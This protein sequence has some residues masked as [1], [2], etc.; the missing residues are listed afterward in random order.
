MYE[1]SDASSLLRARRRL[2]SR[3]SSGPHV[4]RTV[5]L[6]GLTSLFTDVAAEM[7]VTVLPLYLVYVGQFS[8]VA[9]GFVDG[10]QRGA[11]ALVG[12]ASGFVGDRFRRHKEVAATGYGL[13]ALVKLGLATAGTALSAISALVLIDRIG[14]GI[15]TAP[16]DAMISLATPRHELGAAFGVHRALDTTGAMLG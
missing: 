10:I 13:S 11:A 6:L 14:K 7:V 9:F 3:R 1:V 2:L 16:R 12:L 8:P 4:S 5:V 15:R